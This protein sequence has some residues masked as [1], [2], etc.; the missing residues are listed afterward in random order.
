MR[1]GGD[2]RTRYT[3]QAL[4]GII[5]NNESSSR[6]D[7]LVATFS[8]NVG[9]LAYEL[10]QTRHSDASENAV[11]LDRY[12]Y[13]VYQHLGV[14]KAIMPHRTANQSEVQLVVGDTAVMYFHYNHI[15]LMLG[16]NNR[17][18]HYANVPAFKIELYQSVDGISN[19]K[20]SQQNKKFRKK[21]FDKKKFLPKINGTNFF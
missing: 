14:A 1:D 15:G 18:N 19:G 3:Q 6:C 2:K 13:A 17:T 5:T 10:M 8:S 7:Y 11:S 20:F 9:R 4:L 16:R 21:K 12:Y